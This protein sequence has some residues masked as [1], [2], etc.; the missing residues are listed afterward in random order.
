MAN[1]KLSAGGGSSSVNVDNA[2]KIAAFPGGDHPSKDDFL[3]EPGR[4]L[5]R[6][7]YVTPPGDRLAER[8]R[9]LDALLCL[10]TAREAIDEP[11]E[12]FG[13]VNEV[14]QQSVLDLASSL[15]SEVHELHIEVEL[16]RAAERQASHG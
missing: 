9:Y 8:I 10:V 15:A 7:G 1:S 4:T 13:A 6:S 14:I 5:G 3:Y 2:G 16:A 11:G 12:G